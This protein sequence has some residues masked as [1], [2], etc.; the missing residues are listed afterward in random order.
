MLGYH[1][2]RDVR[3]DVLLFIVLGKLVSAGYLA[4][5]WWVFHNHG[6]SRVI[7]YV[8]VHF[9]WDSPI[10]EWVRYLWGLGR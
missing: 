1:D 4:Y 3:N 5:D 9:G 8:V 7:G 6:P 2:W 10:T